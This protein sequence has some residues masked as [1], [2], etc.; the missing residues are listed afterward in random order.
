[1]ERALRETPS[2][3]EP[4][5]EIGQ[6][7]WAEAYGFLGRTPEP[8]DGGTSMQLRGHPSPTA[9]STA[10]RAIAAQT[11]I[12]AHCRLFDDAQAGR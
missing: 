1:M 4:A 2:S 5:D 10:N 8:G 9:V 3:P 12:E 7:S 6:P 11:A